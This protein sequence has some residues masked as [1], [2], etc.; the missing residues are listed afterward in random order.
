MSALQSS[1][2]SL[3][4]VFLEAALRAF[5]A[6]CVVFFVVAFTFIARAL[7]VKASNPFLSDD[8]FW[9]AL[10]IS[11]WCLVPSVIT[12]CVSEYR[13]QSAVK[14]LYAFVTTLQFIALLFYVRSITAIADNEL[15]SSPL[16]LLIW[17]AVPLAWLYFP[18]FFWGRA[19]TL[20]KRGIGI[21]GIL[22]FVYLFA[23]IA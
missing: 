20:F 17:L 3:P 9:V 21:L 10:F 2:S 19:V 5:Y 12:F 4:L 6:T 15:S 8:W 7:S 23:S 11:G 18:I 16:L 13:Y 14:R 1:K 22:G